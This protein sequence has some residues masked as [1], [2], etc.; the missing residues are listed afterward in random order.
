M[1]LHLNSRDGLLTQ[2][3]YY[4]RNS[5]GTRRVNCNITNVIKYININKF[6]IIM[7]IISYSDLLQ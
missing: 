1:F 4:L 6:N 2:S 3:S 5:T 7:L